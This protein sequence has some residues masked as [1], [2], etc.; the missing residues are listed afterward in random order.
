MSTEQH[1]TTA[2][3]IAP[4][5]DLLT[6][7]QAAA[8]LEVAL[9]TLAAWRYRGTGPSYRRLGYRTVRY[10]RMDIIDWLASRSVVP[11]RRDKSRD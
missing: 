10:S 5:E 7:R 1:T 3:V 8:V 2:A 6:P 4:G 9:C 11:Q